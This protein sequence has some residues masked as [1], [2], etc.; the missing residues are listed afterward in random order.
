MHAGGCQANHADLVHSA[1]APKVRPNGDRSPF[2]FLRKLT[3]EAWLRGVAINFD[4]F[5]TLK[6]LGAARHPHAS[7]CICSASEP[8]SAAVPAK[9]HLCATG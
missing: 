9:A 3:I 8:R 7:V 5:A 1:K 4:D 2:R 6:G